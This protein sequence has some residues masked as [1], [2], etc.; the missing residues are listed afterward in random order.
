MQIKV[1]MVKTITAI[2]K[3]NLMK[4]ES[5]YTKV[6]NSIFDIEGLNIYERLKSYT[7]EE[8]PVYDSLLKFKQ[9]YDKRRDFRGK[10]IGI[11]LEQ[12]KQGYSFSDSVRG[13]IPESELN[14]IQAGED[15]KGMAG[16]APDLSTYGDAKFV[17]NVLNMGKKGAIGNMPK[18]NDGRLTNVQKTAVGTYV[19]SLAK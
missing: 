13:W 10:I 19:T 1:I 18:F 9:R 14:L 2:I 4:D 15:G 12:M 16:S 6:P 11:W 8:F 17:V 5:P 7:E 3:G